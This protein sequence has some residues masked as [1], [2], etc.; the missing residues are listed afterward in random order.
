MSRI[1]NPTWENNE[2]LKADI[3]KYVL[4]NLTRK[5]VLDFLGRDYPQYAWSL[6]RGGGYSGFQVS[7]DGDDRRIFLGLKFFIPGLFW[8]RKFGK[9]F[10]G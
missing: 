2:N 9:Y 6:R 3:Q 5:E 4:Q 10:L 1:R 8:V 7:S